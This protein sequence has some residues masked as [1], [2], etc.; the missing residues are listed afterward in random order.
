M[1]ERNPARI[2]RTGG[3]L[4]GVAALGLAALLAAGTA[5]HAEDAGKIAPAE[6]ESSIAP[7]IL[8]EISPPLAGE[9]GTVRVIVQPGADA[10]LETGIADRLDDLDPGPRAGR[11]DEPL[12]LRSVAEIPGGITASGDSA[13]AGGIDP[14]PL[15][16]IDETAIEKG[17]ARAQGD[18]EWS[19]P[20]VEEAARKSFD[21]DFIARQSEF[22]ET[23]LL[24]D[25][26]TRLGKAINTLIEIYGPDAQIEVAPGRFETF[27]HLPAARALRAKLEEEDLQIEIRRLE[28]ENQRRETAL[29]Y[30][31]Q[32]AEIEREE[33]EARLM[34]ARAAAEERGA[35]RRVIDRQYSGRYSLRR[36]FGLGNDLRAVLA[37]GTGEERL[38][39]H[40]GDTLPDGSLIVKIA[41]DHVLID[42]GGDAPE[43]LSIGG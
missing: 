34:A 13:S 29:E 41:A 4:A 24:L 32:R 17:V 39:V 20:V 40:E 6:A 2:L 5:M 22:S 27:S 28:V 16:S 9:E 26:Q 21:T 10:P 7:A 43:K 37:S 23:L 11:N 1:P 19:D 15:A 31:R 36:V 18:P 8:Q 42:R 35:D 30:Q 33:T 12:Q 38:Q 14:E 25:R 3:H